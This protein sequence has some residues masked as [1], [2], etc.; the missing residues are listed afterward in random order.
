M[1][2]KTQ[3]QTKPFAI[4]KAYFCEELA[5]PVCPFCREPF[6]LRFDLTAQKIN[7]LVCTKTECPYAL[8]ENLRLTVDALVEQGRDLLQAAQLAAH[9]TIEPDEPVTRERFAVTD[10]SSANWVLRKLA[11]YK[12]K[13]ERMVEMARQEH[14]VIEARALKIIEPLDRQIFF[15]EQAFADQLR[16]WT[17]AAIQGQKSRS[18]QLLH[19]T[20]G[21]R[22]KPG[23][24]NILDER[25]AIVKAEELGLADLIRVRKEL[26]RT[27]T[28]QFVLDEP[29]SLLAELVKIEA[30]E[31]VFYIKA[32]QPEAR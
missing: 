32:E 13:R 20:L 25:A 27:A 28:K 22:H 8:N 9:Y 26:N 29:D 19:G 12:A 24:L 17:E 16:A 30:G 3:E 14:E 5:E 15:F 31:D 21:F 2:G 11:Y 18:V 10:E 6:T 7:E 4:N 23:K 1:E